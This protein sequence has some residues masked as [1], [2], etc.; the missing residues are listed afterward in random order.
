[1]FYYNRETEVAI[2]R[3]PREKLCF[4]CLAIDMQLCH[5]KDF[6]ANILRHLSEGAVCK[7]LAEIFSG[8]S[9]K[10]TLDRVLF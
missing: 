8:N 2:Q 7:S 1:M 4:N 10:N 5:D 9:Q 6:S 3:C